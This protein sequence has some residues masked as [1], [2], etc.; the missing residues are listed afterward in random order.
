MRGWRSA[1]LLGLCSSALLASEPAGGP[2]SELSLELLEFLGEYGNDQGD[3]NL[4]DDFDSALA[5]PAEPDEPAAS[6][7]AEQTAVP[8]SKDQ[9]AVEKK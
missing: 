5:Q 4:P 3:L 2:D 1:I 7:D 8:A 6:A 9:A